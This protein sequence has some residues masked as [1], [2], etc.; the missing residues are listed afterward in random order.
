MP[1]EGPIIICAPGPEG[2]NNVCPLKGRLCVPPEGQIIMWGLSRAVDDCMHTLLI[3]TGH[4]WFERA[5]YGNL[6]GN[7]ELHK[8]VGGGHVPPVPPSFR[9]L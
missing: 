2:Q 6:R 4:Y 1:P 8:K 7:F 3:D 9:R 5:L